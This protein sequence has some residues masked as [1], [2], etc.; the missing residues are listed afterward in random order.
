MQFQLSRLG[1]FIF[2]E[3]LRKVKV[4]VKAWHMSMQAKLKERENSLLT[5]ELDICDATA[6]LVGLN[7][8]ELVF[9]SALQA[10]I[11]SIYRI[12]GHNFI[13]KSKLNWLAVVDENTSFFHRFLNAKKKKNLIT[14]LKDDEESMTK[15]F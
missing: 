10:E 12:E 14:E 13:Q 7:V 1:W 3:Q 2:N 8:E 11:L 15:S 9:R 4:P 6:V 5:T